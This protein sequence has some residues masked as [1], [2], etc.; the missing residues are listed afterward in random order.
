MTANNSSIF[1]FPEVRVV[2]ASAGS[3][4]TYALAKRYIQLI[5]NPELAQD[6]MAIRQVLALTFTKKAA[7]EMKVRILEFLKKIALGDVSDIEEE[8]ILKPIGLTKALAQK[9]AYHLMDDVIHNYNYFQVQTIDKF[10]N[11]LLSGCAFKIGLT[12][13]FKI[14]NNA[15]DYIEHS[16]DQLIHQAASDKKIYDV[17]QH[18]LHNYLYIEN[19]TGWFPHRDMLGIIETLFNQDN[20]YGQDFL[21]SGVKSDELSKLKIATIE[22][23][24]KLND[25]LPEGTKKTFVTKLASFC[26]KYQKGF[27]ID[28]LST[29][30]QHEEY[31]IKKKFDVPNEIEYL[32]AELRKQITQICELEAMSM[33]NSYIYIYAYVK[34]RFKKLSAKDDVLFLSELNKRARQLFDNDNVTVEELYYRLAT[35]YRHYLIDEFQ[36]T[37]RLQWHNIENMAEEALS[38]GGTLFYVGDRKQAIYGF[39]GGDVRLF[40]EI[41]NQFDSF[42]VQIEPL[43]NNWRSEREVVS[44]NNKIFSQENLHRFITTKRMVD[45]DN[46]SNKNPVYFEGNDLKDLDHVFAT[47]KQ[48]YQVGHEDGYVQMEIVDITGKEECDAY[49]Y[50]R[51]IET[52]EEV[53]TRFDLSDIAIL[54]RNNAQ[55]ELVTSWLLEDD[56]PVQSERT[57]NI[58]ENSI[59]KELVALLNFLNSPINNVAFT[60]FILGDVFAKATGTTKEQ[61]QAFVFSLRT[62]IVKENDFYIYAVFRHEYSDLWNE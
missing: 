9:K 45:D 20:T 11:A 58:T 55:I 54:T 1:Q 6:E 7:Y 44:F 2:E 3:G 26:D 25:N 60:A 40:D 24:N 14:K 46:K 59:I 28:V 61:W 16:L 42:N 49:I 27:D 13:N 41:K 43:T 47:S 53:H 57:S 21:P 51:L 32:W 52:I 50:E 8:V 39:R 12:A 36:D 10:I 22:N 33:F 34:D 19:R 17:F 31:P 56:I 29:S 5:L 4:K 23:F 30:L 38:T 48:S 15:N 37:S 18:F 62:R 35:R